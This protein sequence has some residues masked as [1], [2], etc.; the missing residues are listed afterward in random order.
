MIVREYAFRDLN[1]K[2]CYIDEIP[3]QVVLEEFLSDENVTGFIG[4][5]YVDHL[6]GFTFE[7]MACA[8]K[9]DEDIIV[10]PGNNYMTFKYR[11][12]NVMSKE[13][14]VLD[15]TKYDMQDFKTKIDRVNKIYGSDEEINALRDIVEIDGSRSNEFPDDVLVT[16]YKDNVKPER[17]WFRLEGLNEQYIQGRLLH[18]LTNKG[19]GLETGDVSNL[20]L[21]QDENEKIHLLCFIENMVEK[22]LT[23]ATQAH[24]GQKDKSG[25]DYIQHPITV[26]SFV[27]S[28]EEKIVAYLHDVVEDT[29]IT[30]D[31]LR[32]AGFNENVIFAIDCITKKENEEVEQY[33]ERV[34]QSD[35]AYVVKLA[36]IKHNSD[37]TRFENPT[38]K[39]I[40]RSNNY[41]KKAEILKQMYETNKVK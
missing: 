20:A 38:Q 13:C 27:E 30:L 24:L 26:A 17:A 14:I 7:V 39:D 22:A 32:D 41:L 21:M 29:D 12:R 18:D 25:V 4:Y 2:L 34:I 40:D 5:G 16:L 35:L 28:E 31:D 36:D 15:E 19:Y 23:I 10:Y 8:R 6:A 37:I 1:N 3:N 33:F 9:M 11:M